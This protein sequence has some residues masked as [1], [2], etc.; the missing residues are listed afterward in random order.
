[1]EDSGSPVGDLCRDGELGDGD[2]RF[3]GLSDSIEIQRLWVAKPPVAEVRQSL[4]SSIDHVT[5]LAGDAD[6]SGVAP[7]RADGGS[8][9]SSSVVGDGVDR[10]FGGAGAVSVVDGGV[11]S[12]DGDVVFPDR[13]LSSLAGIKSPVQRS[14]M[15]PAISPSPKRMDVV[16]PLPGVA[17]CRR[18]VVE[19]APDL[20]ESLP[21]QF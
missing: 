12:V 3:S 6:G 16:C 21:S 9:T 18:R 17:I 8:V 5:S 4:L 20:Q 2:G 15:F 10:S 14:S 13:A 11:V 1:M 7:L 19:V